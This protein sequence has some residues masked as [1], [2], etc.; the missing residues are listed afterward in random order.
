MISMSWFEVEIFSIQ[1]R[2]K[3]FI[4]LTLHCI[5]F[6]ASGQERVQIWT[7]RAAPNNGP[8]Y[9]KL[10][11]FLTARNISHV[12]YY[13]TK[14]RRQK[15]ELIC[16]VGFSSVSRVLQWT[17]SWVSSA[18]QCFLYSSR[19]G[20]SLKCGLIR[21]APS[22]RRLKKFR[23]INLCRL[24]TLITILAKHIVISISKITLLIQYNTM[25]V[26][27][28]VQCKFQQIKSISI[29]PCAPPIPL[30]SAV[31]WIVFAGSQFIGAGSEFELPGLK[32]KV[33][34]LRPGWKEAL[35]PISVYDCA[36]RDTMTL[37]HDNSA[38]K[39]KQYG[40]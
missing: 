30:N 26:V 13:G 40:S 33:P 11:L 32:L 19:G 10:G 9:Q 37:I 17:Y 35:Q 7:D 20:V 18:D 6:H 16:D 34:G 8:I 36:V 5:C 28:T 14:N 27:T 2:L 31:F 12:R 39:Q 21:I 23:P 15:M 29:M 1:Y 3:H 25:S 22:S 4:E 38:I 24:P